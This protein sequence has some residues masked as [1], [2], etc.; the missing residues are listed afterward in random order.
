M[1][2][3]GSV[4]FVEIGGC[5]VP[6]DRLY[7]LENEVWYLPEGSDGLARV[8]LLGPLVWFAG[9]F[10]SVSFRPVQGR[11]AEGRSVA[12]VESQRYTGAVRLPLDAEVV[13]R[14]PAIV[15]RPRLLNDAPY[16]D[17]WVVRVRPAGGVPPRLETAAAI[18]D[19]LTERIRQRH[20]RCWPLSPDVEIFEIGIECSAVLA[21]LNDELNRSPAG[22]A[23]LLVT[24]DPTS[25]IEME[26]WADQTGHA[27]LARRR[28]GNLNQF[29]IRKEAHPVPRRRPGAGT[30]SSPGATASR[31]GSG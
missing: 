24:D 14:N 9:R 21:M 11:V 13:E 5:D 8:G 4:S 31:S 25:P 6:E 28:E 22:T 1:R 3:A 26:R 27:L 15:T 19:R 16:G 2:S 29:L 17:G 7:D 23:V 10:Q 20:I 30:G 12:T 18:K